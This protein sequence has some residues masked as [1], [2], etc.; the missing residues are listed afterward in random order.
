MLSQRYHDA[1][2]RRRSK[3]GRAMT[4]SKKKHHPPAAR[5]TPAPAQPARTTTRREWVIR[6]IAVLGII[7]GAAMTLI[8]AT[9][10]ILGGYGKLL[11][12]VPGMIIVAGSCVAFVE[13]TNQARSLRRQRR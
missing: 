6:A 13:T 1:P 10:D 5:A 9:P 3:Q 12:M 4:S 7:A 11:L 2:S 8:G